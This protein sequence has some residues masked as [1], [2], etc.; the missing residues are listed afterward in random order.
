MFSKFLNKH[1]IVLKKGHNVHIITQL[2]INK[3]LLIRLTI[4]KWL[5]GI[6]RPIVHYYAVCWNE[7][8]MLPFMFDYYKRFV[9]FFTIYDN[10]SDDRSEEIIRSH[11]NTEIVKFESNGFNDLVHIDIKNH[12]W[13]RSRGKADYVIV[14]DID[15]FFYHPDIGKLLEKMHQS[16][17]TI[18]Y[19]S[20]YD[21]YSEESLNYDPKHLIT[22]IVLTGVASKKYSKTILFNPNYI[23]EINYE[24]GCHFCHP[25]GCVKPVEDDEIKMLHYKNVGV[26]EMLDRTEI[27]ARRLSEDNKKAEFGIE[28]L[29]NREIIEME[30]YENLHASKEII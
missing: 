12:C 11:R 20:G 16:K 29:R 27:L 6:H 14:C 7:E 10:G 13:K 18:T 24:P 25:V 21:M 1:H 9:D 5:H 8:K 15:E 23:V 28:Y 26:K 19:P 17:S 4:Y 3:V 30:F 2:L 22:E